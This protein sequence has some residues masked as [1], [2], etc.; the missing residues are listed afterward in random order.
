MVL[1]IRS[2][3]PY[4]RDAEYDL[5][6]KLAILF[7]KCGNTPDG[8]FNVTSS[9]EVAVGRRPYKNFN[10]HLGDGSFKGCNEVHFVIS[11][12]IKLTS[13]IGSYFENVFKI[14]NF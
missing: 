6:H 4:F 2:C 7:F 11:V 1:T 8:S 12:S 3:V 13:Y 10:G 5:K 9:R 14:L